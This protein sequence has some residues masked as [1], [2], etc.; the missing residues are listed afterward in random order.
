MRLEEYITSC[1]RCDKGLAVY[2]GEASGSICVSCAME[3]GADD[4]R[5]SIVE[6]LRHS[7]SLDAGPKDVALRI[8]EALIERKHYT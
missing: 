5:H 3:I 1:G 2:R 4:E 6:W 8:A 7:S